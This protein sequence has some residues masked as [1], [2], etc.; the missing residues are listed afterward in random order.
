LQWSLE[1]RRELRA[2]RRA[3]CKER[4]LV[5]GHE[6]VSAPGARKNAYFGESPEIVVAE[7]VADPEHP[8][9]LDQLISSEP[10]EGRR[11]PSA[12]PVSSEGGMGHFSS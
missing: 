8:G 2:N 9:E 12:P 5:D 11:I 7:R 4:N 1:I 3:T 6:S 10:S